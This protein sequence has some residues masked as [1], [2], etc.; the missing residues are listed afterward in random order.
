[1]LLLEDLA[2]QL[3]KL[4][5]EIERMTGELRVLRYDLPRDA[6]TLVQL[7]IAAEHH[8]LCEA[9][10]RAEGLVKRVRKAIAL[11]DQCER[12]LLKRADQLETGTD[13]ET[14]TSKMASS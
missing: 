14:F 12:M 4:S 8:R 10:D 11:F 9:T 1:M 13:L 5:R 6:E 7:E 2:T 3:A